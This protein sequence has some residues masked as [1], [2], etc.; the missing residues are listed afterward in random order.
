LNIP[1]KKFKI[2]WVTRKQLDI[3][4]DRVTWLETLRILGNMGH[5]VIL[6][7][8]Y[9]KD[10]YSFGLNGQIKYLPSIKT[11]VLNYLISHLLYFIYLCY[12]LLTERPNIVIFHPSVFLSVILFTV[13]RKIKIIKIKFVMDVRTIPVEIHGISDRAKQILFDLS[14]YASKYFFDGLSVITPFMKKVLTDQYKLKTKNIGIWTSG[15][16]LEL[17]DYKQHDNE[18]V[19]RLQNKW[20]LQNKFV[21]IYHG[22]FTPSRGL[23]ESIEAINLLRGKCP[24]IVL[25]LVGDGSDRNFLSGLTERFELRNHVIITGPVRHDYIPYYIKLSDIGILP[26]PNLFWW[27]VSSPIKLMEYMAMAKPVIVSDIE[28]H[29]DVIKSNGCGIFVKSN[30]P[31]DLANGILFAY[32]NKAQMKQ[33]GLLGRKIVEERFTWQKQVV[34]L[35]KYLQEI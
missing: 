7:S 14:I 25:L 8:M 28:A 27:R 5:K 34:N 15:V 17:F 16:S 23:H 30:A 33:M 9:K 21:I 19:K 2:I 1:E 20:N 4:L 22:V 11:K 24:D 13:L 32:E 31:V 18:Y 29:R 6:L 3:N 10:K 26:F 12:Y 35:D